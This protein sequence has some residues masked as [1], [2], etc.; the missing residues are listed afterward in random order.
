[1]NEYLTFHRVVDLLEQFQKESPILNSFGFGNLIDF[2]R[3]VSASTVN[4]PYMFVV[5]L[6]I[7]YSE[8][9]TE[10]QFSIIFAD[11]LNYDLSNEKECV[12]DMS[13]QAKRFMSYL[14]RGINT[15]PALYDN[16]DIILPTGAIP[17]M[18]RFGDHTAGVAL[19]CV[20]QVF[21]D[22]NACDFYPSPTPTAQPTSTPTMTPTNTPSPEVTPTMTMTPSPSETCG[23]TTQYLKV[24]LQDSTKFKLQLFNDQAYTSPADA[25]CDYA[26]SGVAYGDMGTIYF[27]QESIDFGQHNKQFDLAGVLLPGEVVSYFSVISV[28]TSGCSCPVDV[29]FAPDCQ[30]CNTSDIENVPFCLSGGTGDF[31][32]MNGTYNLFPSPFGDCGWFYN[33]GTTNVEAIFTSPTN[34]QVSFQTPPFIEYQITIT[35][36]NCETPQFLISPSS[37]SGIGVPPKLN[38][39][40]PCS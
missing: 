40:S 29:K 3:T 37:S 12:S 39:F 11:I 23:L 21:E 24:E 4:Y 30:Y 6:S 22:L 18:E 14:K 10:Y 26:V 25:L 31:A 35:G 19:D 33:D 32:V 2:S 1:M 38:W 15:F 7:N 5:P 34:I 36:Q 9:L 16:L 13:L 8:N 28:D 17:F 20:L 27:G